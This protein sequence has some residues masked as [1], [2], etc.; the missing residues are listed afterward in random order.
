MHGFGP[1]VTFVSVGTCTINADQGGSGN[2]NPAPQVQRSFQV[3]KGDQLISFA[4]LADKRFDESPT[5]LGRPSS[6]GLTVRSRRRRRVSARRGSGA[7]STFVSVGTCT[8]DADQ[9]GSGNWNPAPQ[10]QRSFQVLKG[11]QVISFAALADKRFDESL[12][13]AGTASSGLT[14]SFTS[15]TPGV[16]TTGGPSGATVAFVS[17][18]TCTINADQGGSG[19]WNPAPQVQRSFQ[20]LKG[21]QVISFAALADKRFDESLTVAGT[22]SSGLTV[23][24]T[25]ATP[26]VC[27]T[28]G[29]N[30]A[31]VAFVSTGTCTINADQG[32]SGNWNPAPQ[33]QRSF[34]VLKGN[35]SIAFTSTAPSSATAGGAPYIATATASSGLT[36]TFGTGSLAVCTS[37]GTNGATFSFTAVGTCIVNATQPGNAN[38]N[39]AAPVAQTFAVGKASP[40][41]TV[42]A[43]ATGTVAPPSQLLR[44][45][46]PSHR[47]RGRTRR[48]RSRSGSSG[49]SPPRRRPARAAGRRSGRRRPRGTAR[50]SRAPRS[51]RRAPGTYW[52]Y[53]SS[54]SD[55]N[56]NAA[57]SACDSPSM[58]TTVVTAAATRL[59][60]TSCSTSAG[61]SANCATVGTATVTLK[62]ANQGGGTWTARVTLVDASGNPI[63]N[64]TGSTIV[65]TV[66]KTNG[67]AVLTFSTG[68]AL[69]VPNGS[70]E[71]SNTFTYDNAG[72]SN[73]NG[74]DTVTGSSAGL[75][76]A[77]GNVTW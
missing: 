60:F 77:T 45:R 68:T 59:S 32:G 2:W 6:S 71:S 24:F 50:T 36:V 15:A 18:G 30:G 52:W 53:V 23:S 42:S 49:R 27:T 26:G 5:R 46:R 65:V 10:V 28:G 54:P 13:V 47:A 8:V 44:S 55:T 76:S 38:W 69:T 22:A 12:T 19:N 20:V 29:P 48:R 61:S 75:T 17:A 7:R 74:T 4:A 73:G 16:C 1:S 34:Q 43:P 62:K 33:V 3:L 39:A 35:Q 63:V 40:T 67:N 64:T 21:D 58:T 56:N 14:V 41:L 25:S 66:S 11:D 51:R 9:G 70:S 57:A 37:G 31:T 72:V